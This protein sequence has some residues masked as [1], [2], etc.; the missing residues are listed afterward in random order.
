VLAGH[1]HRNAIVPRRSAAGGYWLIT[2]ASV[3]DWPQ[4]WRMLR[5]VRTA[6]GGLALETWMV[7][8]TGRPNDEGDL[9]GLA[10]DLAY[11]DPQG[12]RPAEAEGSAT[13]RNVRLHLPARALRAP[14]R[15]GRPRAL[16]PPAPEPTLGAGDT[17]T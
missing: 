14:L 5:L 17:V 13:A 12:G 10:R 3:V 6:G 15:P 1:T 9:A 2:T 11:L 4:Q 8:H 16:P 7:D